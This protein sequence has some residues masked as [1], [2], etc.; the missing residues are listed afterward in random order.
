MHM[1]FKAC[2]DDNDNTPNTLDDAC[3]GS[4]CKVCQGDNESYFVDQWEIL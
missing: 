4:D 1:P 2:R 3:T